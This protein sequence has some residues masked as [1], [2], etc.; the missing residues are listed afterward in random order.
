MWY[1]S[2]IEIDPPTPLTPV[3]QVLIKIAKN[4]HFSK[5]CC[6]LWRTECIHALLLQVSLQ[7]NLKE[8]LSFQ[9]FWKS[10]TF[11]RMALVGRDLK[12]NWAPTTC[13][14]QDG[15][16]PNQVPR[17]PHNPALRTSRD[18]TPTA[19]L[20]NIFQLLTT[21][22][23]KNLFLTSS[24]NLPS[25]SLKLF[26]LVLWLS[27]CIQSQFPSCLSVAFKY[28]K[29]TMRSFSP[30]PSLLQ[31]KQAQLSQPFIIKELLQLSDHLHGPPLPLSNLKFFVAKLVF[32]NSLLSRCC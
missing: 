16:P 2:Q 6:C 30:E 23:V 5:F 13:H 19:P 27:D 14:V 24:I 11:H 20:G 4:K 7:Q 21:P 1:Y 28:W 3:I 25:F 10:S 8:D 15:H 32:V 22:W 31:A 9:E 26:L 29:A 18:G 12:D 17:A